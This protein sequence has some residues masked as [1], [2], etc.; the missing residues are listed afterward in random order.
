VGLVASIA[1]SYVIDTFMS[2]QSSTVQT[3]VLVAIAG[4]AAFFIANPAIVAGI[5][6]GLLLTPLAKIVYTAVPSLANPAVA[7]P[8]VSAGSGMSALHLSR[9][10]KQIRALHMM[11]KLQ[12]HKQLRALHLAKKKG[13]RALHMR[14]MSNPTLARA[15]QR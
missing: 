6:T 15:F 12:G 2:T 13:I 5:A 14:G 8:T 1:V 3:G 11:G 10:Q 4:G 9:K 7:V